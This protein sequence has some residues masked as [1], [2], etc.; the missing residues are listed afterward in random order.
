MGYIITQENVIDEDEKSAMEK[1]VDTLT[2]EEKRLL[3]IDFCKS[4]DL[5]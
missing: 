3:I 1:F 4:N 2:E 5:L